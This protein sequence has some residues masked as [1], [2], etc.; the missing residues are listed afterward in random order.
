MGNWGKTGGGMAVGQS[1]GA[2]QGRMTAENERKWVYVEMNGN[3][4]RT[5]EHGLT[6][7]KLNEN[8]GYNGV[9]RAPSEEVQK[10]TNRWNF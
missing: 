5:I 1:D 9:I 4:G 6:I 2:A 7:R 3:S 8:E 10:E